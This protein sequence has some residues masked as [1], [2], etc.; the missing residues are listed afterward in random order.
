MQQYSNLKSVV[1]SLAPGRW[2]CFLGMLSGTTVRLIP[3][4]RTL[5]NNYLHTTIEYLNTAKKEKQ[6]LRIIV[7]YG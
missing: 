4:Y 1:L 3:I 6:L 5:K 2:D 7:N